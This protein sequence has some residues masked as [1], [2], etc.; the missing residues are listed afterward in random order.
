MSRF[1][2]YYAK[3]HRDVAVMPGQVQNRKF[4]LLDQER[5]T[6]RRAKDQ[7]CDLFGLTLW[8]ECS[9][10]TN[11]EQFAEFCEKHGMLNEFKV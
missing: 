7:F 4:C 6:I 5:L 10:V 2:K 11:A 1:K 9:L 3:H 8:E